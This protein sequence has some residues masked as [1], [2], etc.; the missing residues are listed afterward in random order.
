LGVGARAVQVGAPDEA[1]GIDR[2]ADFPAK[3]GFTF[4]DLRHTFGSLAV[5]VWP[6]TDVRAYMGHADIQTTM[7]YSHHVPKAKAA[8]ELSE[9]IN[10]Q[11]AVPQSVPR[12]RVEP[13]DT[14]HPL[15]PKAAWNALDRHARADS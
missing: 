15:P 3:Q 9:F 4:H 14:G 7:R 8:A 5:Q 13:S 11:Q 12:N 10:S 6:L 1:A 2:S